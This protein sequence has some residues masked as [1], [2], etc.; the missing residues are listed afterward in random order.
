MDHKNQVRYITP[1]SK[2]NRYGEIAAF[3][4]YKT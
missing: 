1:P 3:L 2:L 4:R